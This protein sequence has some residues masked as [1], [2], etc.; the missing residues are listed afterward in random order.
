MSRETDSRLIRHGI[1]KFWSLPLGFVNSLR[2]FIYDYLSSKLSKWCGYKIVKVIY[3]YKDLSLFLLKQ[4]EGR[5][6][7]LLWVLKLQYSNLYDYVRYKLGY[8]SLIRLKKEKKSLKTTSFILESSYMLISLVLKRKNV[9]FLSYLLEESKDI[10]KISFLHTA[11]NNHFIQEIKK[12]SIYFNSLLKKGKGTI[13]KRRFHR[14]LKMAKYHMLLKFRVLSIL[15]SNVIFLCYKQSVHVKISSIFFTQVGSES[16][17][18]YNKKNFFSKDLYILNEFR[19]KMVAYAS[20]I[21]KSPQLLTNAITII[22]RKTRKKN[23]IRNVLSFLFFIKN[24]FNN[25]SLVSFIGF[26]FKVSGKLSGKLRKSKF[27][28][29]LGKIQL[30]FLNS[31]ITYHSDI[32]ITQYGVFGLKLWIS[33]INEKNI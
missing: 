16:L 14:V 21:S 31:Y 2:R 1:T 25:Q 20:L 18:L 32:A 3:N 27:I 12:I 30:L 26:R 24:L 23:H 13:I 4:K 17:Y 5:L 11:I 29:K 28:Y 8:N 9:I 6:R 22:L 10:N 15:F 19:Q 7:N 33:E